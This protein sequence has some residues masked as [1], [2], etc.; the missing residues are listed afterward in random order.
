MSHGVSF[1]VSFGGVLF[2]GL[3]FRGVSFG[4]VS[5]G[6]VLF[7]VS[8]GVSFQVLDRTQNYVCVCDNTLT[9]PSTVCVFEVYSVTCRL[10]CP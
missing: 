8:F 10:K 7:G 1:G 4:G 6:G 3:S 5:F 9:V 2:G